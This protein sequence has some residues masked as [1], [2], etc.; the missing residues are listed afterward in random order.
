MPTTSGTR[1]VRA[2]GVGLAVLLA[3]ASSACSTGTT[4][5]EVPASPDATADTVDVAAT[6]EAAAVEIPAG[7]VVGTATFESDVYDV[8]GTVDVVHAPGTKVGA[9]AF[10][11][12]L[13]IRDLVLPEQFSDPTQFRIV[14]EPNSG[15]SPC[16]GSWGGDPIASFDITDGAGTLAFGNPF[17]DQNPWSSDLDPSWND[18]LIILDAASE[19]PDENG[20]RFPV[21]VH[22][23]FEWS[24][25]DVRPDLLVTDGQAADGATGETSIDDGAPVAYVVAPNDTLDAV[26]ARFGISAQD[27]LFLNPARQN[28]TSTGPEILIAGERLNLTKDGR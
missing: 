11:W 19:T 18:S 22:A 27:L 14:A 20:C 1:T 23:D 8:S 17:P 2:I 5:S 6:P 9:T 3:A 7:T 4:A 15:T 10:E 13:V 24:M 21:A 26:A 16:M 25:P 28:D 12:T